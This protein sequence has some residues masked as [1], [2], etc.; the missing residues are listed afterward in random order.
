MLYAANYSQLKIREHEFDII[1]SSNYNKIA[2]LLW[3]FFFSSS[4]VGQME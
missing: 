3:M 4:I 2:T 1:S